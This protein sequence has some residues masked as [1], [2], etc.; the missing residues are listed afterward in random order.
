[1]PKAKYKK[2]ADGRYC[3]HVDLGKREDGTRNRVTVYGRT[4][5]EIDNKIRELKNSIDDKTYVSNKNSVTFGQYADQFIETKRATVSFRTVEM[6]ESIIRN[7]SGNI[8]G[9]K[10]NDISRAD[11]QK[12]INDNSSKPR[13]CQKI[14]ICFGSIFKQAVIDSLVAKNPMIGVK[15]PVYHSEEKRALTDDEKTLL[16]E[17]EFNPKQKV[18]LTVIQ[19]YGLRKEEA[20]ALRYDSFDWKNSEMKINHACVFKNSRPTEQTTKN[21][22]TRTLKL[23]PEDA[24]LIQEYIKTVDFSEDPH[25]FKNQDG[26][27]IS[28]IGFRR[29]WESILYKMSEQAKKMDIPVPQNLTC[30]VFRHNFATDCYYAGIPILETK[31]L[32]GHKSVGVLMQIYTHLDEKKRDP[33]DTLLTYMEDQ[34][35]ERKKQKEARS[36][37]RSSQRLS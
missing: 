20:L 5:E 32:T 10:I 23:F 9:M 29:M 16:E 17:T 11:I 31:R 1:M 6:Y 22:E 33:R 28:A 36:E 27:W 26:R 18:F 35:K 4:I 34:R 19:H 25:I 12:I 37:V 14:Q 13:T 24:A 15:A 3:T 7:Y 30:H 2:R 8:S 21:Y